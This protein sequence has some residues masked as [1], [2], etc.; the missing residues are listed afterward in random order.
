[1]IPRLFGRAYDVGG[2]GM[3]YGLHMIFIKTRQREGVGRSSLIREI[4]SKAV[5]PHSKAVSISQ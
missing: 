5:A 3:N 2:G 1:M 4:F